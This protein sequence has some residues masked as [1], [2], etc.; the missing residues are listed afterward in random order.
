MDRAGK[1]GARSGE[2]RAST[3]TAAG[4]LKQGGIARSD[5]DGDVSA[6][7][8]WPVHKEVFEGVAAFMSV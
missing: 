8:I 2:R 1:L 6:R 4:K 3:I 5:P 7:V